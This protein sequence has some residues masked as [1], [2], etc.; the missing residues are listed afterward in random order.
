MKQHEFGFVP[1]SCTYKL[2][3]FRLALGGASCR[4]SLFCIT[5]LVEHVI[6]TQLLL[7]V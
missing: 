3:T 7:V 4:I 6:P 1:N 2:K 5:R